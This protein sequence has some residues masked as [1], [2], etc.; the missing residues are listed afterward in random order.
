M[1]NLAKMPL[2][3]FVGLDLGKDLDVDHAYGKQ[4]V[5][6]ANKYA[7]V[8]WGAPYFKGNGAVD[9]WNTYDK[10]F[11]TPIA[12]STET[13][14]HPNPGDVVIWKMNAHAGTG[15]YGHV[16]ICLSSTAQLM[17]LYSQN[18]PTGAPC[19]LL[20]LGF[21]GVVGWLAPNGVFASN[22]PTTTT[23]GVTSAVHPPQSAAEAL[24]VFEAH[25]H[26]LKLH[27]SV[28]ATNDFLH[29]VRGWPIFTK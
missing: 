21:D 11:W 26:D 2:L 25:L 27:P 3:S 20:N 12:N 10:R 18:Y 9:F 28:Q 16:A 8:V 22:A 15:I 5:D 24:V 17:H 19:S 14:N 7:Q 1:P 6:L 13:N 4:C 23:G 29:G